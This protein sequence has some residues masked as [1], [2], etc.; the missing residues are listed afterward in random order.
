MFSF[1]KTS[2][3]VFGFLVLFIIGAI[4][5]L[6]YQIPT[7]VMSKPQKI[8]LTLDFKQPVS[9]RKDRSPIDIINNDT[10]I[11]LL[12][13][14]RA[15]EAASK[16]DSVKGI[17]ALFGSEQPSMTTVQE[18]LPALRKF[19]DTGKFS[20]A[21]G[22]S[23]GDF[24]T[25]S[26]SYMLASVFDN[27]WLQ[28]VGTVSLTGMGLFAPFAKEAF[29]KVGVVP[30]FMQREEYKNVMDFAQMT[31]FSP[32][33]R[34]ELTGVLYSLSNQLAHGISLNRR[35]DIDGVK[36]L[37]KEGPFIDEDALAN[38][39][40]TKLA[41]YDELE[42][43]VK[44]QAGG[45]AGYIDASTYLSFVKSDALLQDVK[46]GASGTKVALIYALGNIVEGDKGAFNSDRVAN[47]QDIAEAFRQAEEDDEIRAVVFRIDSPGGSPVASETIR[48][49]VKN[50][51][52]KKKPVIVS[53]GETAG[54]GGYWIAMDA[55]KIV[56]NGATITG[57][58]GVVAGKFAAEEG[59]KK[60]GVSIDEITM[61][62]NAGM[63]NMFRTFSE[64]Q[65]NKVNALLDKTYDVFVKG[66]S[67]GRKIPMSKMPSI[68]KGRIFTGEQALKVGL[69]D[70]VGGYDAAFK[71]V[72]DVLGL[73]ANAKLSFT[74]LPAEP[75]QFEK[76]LKL[77]KEFSADA[78]KF[79]SFMKSA[80]LFS[81]LSKTPIV[82]NTA[83]ISQEPVLAVMGG[84]YYE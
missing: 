78:D 63:W 26:R 60:I 35:K 13:V 56:A 80:S 47:S 61:S 69:I 28:P 22:T 4:V 41:Y 7:G 49:A 18:I 30:D 29:E 79:S 52:K 64:E 67:E 34:E 24:G 19:R 70:A 57:S 71:A 77:L 27:I 33:V 73:D 3:A 74:V 9:E 62:S 46:K 36:S 50:V 53:M 8:I 31:E 32:H 16:D 55:D 20:Y 14:I 76:I 1:I 38:G 21:F 39:L 42:E 17:V 37:M 54:S 15:I 45:D 83:L 5:A 81:F 10:S 25:G 82:Q 48:R 68:A 75:S 44:K 58:I 84:V 51:Q 23:F 59:L 72:R 12:D 40:I 43:E 66:V 6:V 11:V 2:L 65:K